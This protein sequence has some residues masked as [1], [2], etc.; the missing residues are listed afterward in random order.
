MMGF[1]Y[2]SSSFLASLKIKS[3]SKKKQES[4]KL[5]KVSRFRSG[6]KYSRPVFFFGFLS[7]NPSASLK[8]CR[9]PVMI[10]KLRK[11]QK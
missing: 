8:K 6:K 5:K 1:Y 3:H 2:A 11:G 7:S 9:W 10:V 4:V